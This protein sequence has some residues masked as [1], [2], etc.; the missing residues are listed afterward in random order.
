MAA[1]SEAYASGEEKD[2]Q[3]I[4]DGETARPES[5]VGDDVP[6]RLVR[7]LRKIAQ[8]RGRFAQLVELHAGRAGDPMWTL[9][10]KVREATS[11]GEDPLAETERDLRKADS[12]GARVA[13]G[14]SRRGRWQASRVAVP[15][16]LSVLTDMRYAAQG[17]VVCLAGPLER[18]SGREW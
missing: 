15:D 1:A 6:S 18:I 10:E 5:V 8:V 2:L 13:R 7:V 17:S 3:R 9:F 16:D 4:F 12:H 11:P 14:H